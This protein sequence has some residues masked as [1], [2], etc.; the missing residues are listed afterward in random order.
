MARRHHHPD[1]SSPLEHQGAQAISRRLVYALEINVAFLIVEAVGGYFTNSLALLTDAGHMFTDVGALGLALAAR[2]LATRPATDRRTFGYLRAE[3]LAAFLNSIL[4]WVLVTGVLWE[5]IQR[6]RHPEPIASG[7]MT[8]IAVLGLAA[9]LASAWLLR[10]SQSDLNIRGAYLH[11]LSDALGS[12]GALGA[13]IFLM[14]GGNP[15]ADPLVSLLIAGLIF[16][17]SIG[18]MRES[19][20]ILMEATPHSLDISAVQRTLSTLPGVTEVHDLHIWQVGTGLVSLT[21]HLIVDASTDRDRLLMQAQGALR[22]MH[23]IS[24]ATLQIETAE[25]HRFLTTQEHTVKL[26]RKR[27]PSPDA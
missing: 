11:L 4:L 3:I 20:D 16:W 9:N 25:L 23:G 12:V 6:V 14:L 21:G 8:I 27:P 7:W 2:W 18:L 17:A 5:A 1:E 22:S 19:L 26:E 15:I 13:G 24:H 10:G